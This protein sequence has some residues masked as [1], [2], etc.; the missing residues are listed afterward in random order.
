M[1]TKEKKT[2][3][4]RP[5]VFRMCKLLGVQEGVLLHC[6]FH[7]KDEYFKTPQGER[8]HNELDAPWFAAQAKDIDDLIAYPMGKQRRYVS[9]FRKMGILTAQMAGFPSYRYLKINFNKLRAVLDDIEHG[10]AEAPEQ[11]D[12]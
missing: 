1:A 2:K 9:S 4:E 3:K 12:D 11:D 5:S 8:V 6:L 7:L 10:K